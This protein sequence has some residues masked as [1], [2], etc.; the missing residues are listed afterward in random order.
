MSRF[1]NTTT[2]LFTAGMVA[3]PTDPIANLSNLIFYLKPGIGQTL[4]GGK[5]SSW[6]DAVHSYSISQGTDANR[7]VVD[8]TDGFTSPKFDGTNDF[9]TGS[10]IGALGANW[11]CTFFMLGKLDTTSTL[12]GICSFSGV[13][14][15]VAPFYQA[16][17]LCIFDNPSFALD[18]SIDLTP[19]VRFA[20]AFVIG[21]N[22]RAVWA[23]RIGIDS[24]PIK[25][26]ENS[27]SGFTH[28]T[29]TQ[30]DLG[31]L[32]STYFAKGPIHS[33]ALSS[34]R[35]SDANITACLSYLA[36]LTP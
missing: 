9:L 26:G 29:V 23:K 6:N 34:V 21:T 32:F 25:F 28:N 8:T 2:N 12:Q 10:A 18:T 5:L 27:T 14:T 22:Y 15:A 33:V 13:S 24:T 3:G 35:E 4:V 17:D 1:L 36:A 30:F 19:A 31:Q 20:A 7:P 11:V 16:D